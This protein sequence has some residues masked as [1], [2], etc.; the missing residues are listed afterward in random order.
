MHA[1]IYNTII[2]DETQVPLQ[3][4]GDKVLVLL[5][6]YHHLMGPEYRTLSPYY[7]SLYHSN[8][9]NSDN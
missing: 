6:Q 8:D 2:V 5:L 3:L 9:Y 7:P 4:Q 1:L